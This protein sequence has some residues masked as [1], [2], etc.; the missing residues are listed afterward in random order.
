MYTVHMYYICFKKYDLLQSTLI[1]YCDVFVV[2]MDSYT[3]LSEVGACLCSSKQYELGV[4]VLNVA[5][6]L[7]TNQKGITMK[8]QLTL[9]NA[10]STLGHVDLAISFYQVQVNTSIT[11]ISSATDYILNL[12]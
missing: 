5:Q 1:F 9:A 2:D 7:A 3:K 6:K 8:V 10:H 12:S 11:S 4:E